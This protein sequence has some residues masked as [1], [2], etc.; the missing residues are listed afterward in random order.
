MMNPIML[1]EKPEKIALKT[2]L[3][4]PPVTFPRRIIQKASMNLAFSGPTKA[5][6]TSHRI[7][8]TIKLPTTI[9]AE[10]VEDYHVQIYRHLIFSYLR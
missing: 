9:P 10:K 6:P 4:I 2:V 3:K 5:F 1:A 8:D 7:G